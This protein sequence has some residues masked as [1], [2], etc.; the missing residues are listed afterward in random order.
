MLLQGRYVPSISIFILDLL[1]GPIVGTTYSLNFSPRNS[2]L[3]YTHTDI[4]SHL[5]TQ[6]LTLRGRINKP[7]RITEM[8]FKRPSNLERQMLTTESVLP[9]CVHEYLFLPFIFNLSTPLNQ[10]KLINKPITLSKLYKRTL[11]NF[12]CFKTLA[13]I[14]S[15]PQSQTVEKKRTESLFGLRNDSK[16]NIL[17]NN[18]WMHE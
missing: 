11:W 3:K 17:M 14:Y 4:H 15:H 12:N 6:T 18:I 1:A 13:M 7:I 10:L 2:K 9:V 16:F 5:L 8:L